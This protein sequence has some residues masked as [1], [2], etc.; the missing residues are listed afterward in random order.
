MLRAR[1]KQASTGASIVV[2]RTICVSPA[3]FYHHCLSALID[4]ELYRLFRDK[5]FDPVRKLRYR[6]RA[7]RLLLP[8]DAHV[9]R[10]GL[11]FL[12]A[13]HYQE[14]YFLQSMLT[15]FGVHLFIAV[16]QMNPRAGITQL[17]RDLLRVLGMLLA[18]G[19]D[20]HLHRR[21][22]KREGSGIMLDQ[23]AE[24]A[25]HRSKQRAMDH[26]RLLARAVFGDIFELETLRQV[27]VELDR[28]KLPRPAN[29]VHQFDVDLG[30]IERG[31]AGD[32][33]VGNLQLFQCTLQR[34]DRQLPFLI[35]A[36]EVLLVVGIPD[37]EFHVELIEA[38]R[39]QDRERKLHAANYFALNLLRRA[40]DMGIILRESAYPEQT[41]HNP[42]PFIAIH[43]S[44]LAVAGRQ[45]PV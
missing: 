40:E 37:A 42:R 11:R 3:W 36:Q 35:A 15:N 28:A 38:E 7:F 10:S 9:Y 21:E 18:D 17:L 34:G 14:R 27:E 13:D 32:G 2:R 24:K 31:F 25:L 43:G 16:V 20:R 41:V 6:H 19:N 30:A 26:E 1:S 22:P 33:F 8:A 45:V 39:L 29:G 44:Q 5:S 12:F 23:N 4:R